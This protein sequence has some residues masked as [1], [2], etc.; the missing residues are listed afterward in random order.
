MALSDGQLRALIT[1]LADLYSTVSGMEFPA[2]VVS[3]VAGLIESDSCSYNRV[4]SSGHTTWHIEP[5][6][7]GGFP[8]ASDLFQQHMPKHPVLA[9]HRATDEGTARR[10]SDFLSDRQ[11][12]ALGLYRDF[13]RHADVHYQVAIAVPAPPEGIIGVAVNRKHRDFSSDDA[14]LLELL[15]PHIGRAVA[16]DELMSRPLPGPLLGPSGSPILTPRQTRVLQLVA[17]GHPDRRIARLLGIS[18]RTVHSHLQN[19]YRALGVTSRTEALARLDH[20]WRND[21]AGGQRWPWSPEHP[22]VHMADH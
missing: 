12:R 11:F 10:I 5:A 20:R 19:I 22:G 18:T 16:V 4:T 21:P 7:V 15:R 2:K 14:E 3:V 9:Y 13:Y 17:A 1:G 6:G 8:G